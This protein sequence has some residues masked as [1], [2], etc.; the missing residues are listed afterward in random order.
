MTRLLDDYGPHLARLAGEA[1]VDAV[2]ASEGRVLL[3]EVM[4]TAPPLLRGTANAE[5][6]AALGADLVCCNMFDPLDRDAVPPGLEGVEPAASGLTG[7]GRLL[8]RPVGLNLEPDIDSVPA[9]YRATAERV[10]EA[11]DGGG[12]FVIV[13][14]NPARGAAIADIA[15]AVRTVRSTAPDLVC[16][17]G[18]M[19]HSGRTEPLGPDIVEVL[20]AAGAHGV[21]VPVPGTLPGLSEATAAAMVAEAHA[22]GLLAIGTIGT[23]QEGADRQTVRQLA[24]T[25]K[26]IGVDIHHLGDAG[27]DGVAAPENIYA[28]SVAVRGVRHTWNRMARNVR[29]SWGGPT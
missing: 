3:A 4:A 9:A 7:L 21:L 11:A 8:G 10:A 20:G 2:T 29:A 25:A 14:A 26:R 23:S 15:T 5:V 6:A 27:L 12:A 16:L 17:A 19:H 22:A 1:L 28:Y 13:T 24:V 18:K